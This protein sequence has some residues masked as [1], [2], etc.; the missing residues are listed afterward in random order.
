MKWYSNKGEHSDVVLSTRIRLARNLKDY[1]FPSCLNTAEKEKVNELLKDIFLSSNAGKDLKFTEMSS[2]PSVKAV[3]L[4]EKHLISPEFA[5]DT[6][7]R[8]LLISEDEDVSIMLCEEDHARIQVILPGLALESAYEKALEFDKALEEKAAIAFDERLGY[9]TQCPTN[10]GTGMRASA[11]LHL[12]ALAKTGMIPRLAAT[13][14]KLGLTLRGSYGDTNRA[15][16][17]LFQLSNQ[18]TLGISEKAAVQNLNAIALQIAQQENQARASLLK[19][20][21]FIDRIWRAYG[22]LNSA[23][24]ISCDEFCDLLSYVRLAAARGLVDVPLET[25]NRL[26][27]EMQP[28]TINADNDSAFSSRERDVFRAKKVKEALCAK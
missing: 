18:V 10:L 9:L 20:D 15:V 25:L 3:S 5:S 28:A 4:A 19:D 21:T 17:D 14:A 26:F 24:M 2:L 22:I 12:P 11:M 1:P 6:A 8:A 27:V 23:H 16:G 13:V 7:G